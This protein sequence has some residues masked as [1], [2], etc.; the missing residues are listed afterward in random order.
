MPDFS[1][2]QSENFEES[3]KEIDQYEQVMSRT[4]GQNGD[5]KHLFLLCRGITKIM[6][7]TCGRVEV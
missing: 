2:T 4:G 5:D 7:K 6:R 1:A 3:L